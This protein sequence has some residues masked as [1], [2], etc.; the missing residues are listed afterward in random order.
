MTPQL[1]QSWIAALRSGRY[2]QG[3]GL[4]RQRRL[5]DG[6]YFCAIGVLFDLVATAMQ[7]DRLTKLGVGA[8]ITDEVPGYIPPEILGEIGMSAAQESLIAGLNDS[9]KTFEQIADVIERDF[10]DERHLRRAATALLDGL[11]HI[12]PPFLLTPKSVPDWSA[13]AGIKPHAGGS[14]R[15][16]IVYPTWA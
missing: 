15:P 13:L 10:D 14:A 2:R 5:R 12:P 3:R 16:M 1:K 7:W 9:G 8:G 11:C 4:L 6:T